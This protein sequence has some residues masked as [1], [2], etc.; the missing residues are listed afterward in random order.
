MPPSNFRPHFAKYQHPFNFLSA[1]P[2]S[3]IFLSIL[4]F[5]SFF[6]NVGILR[7]ACSFN[8]HAI[9]FVSAVKKYYSR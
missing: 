4:V 8:W 3:R 6:E 7:Q 9:Y 2:L 1:L 5:S